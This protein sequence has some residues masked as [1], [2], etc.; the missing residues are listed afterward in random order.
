MAEKQYII[1][2]D[3]ERKFVILP[4]PTHE[5][6]RANLSLDSDDHIE[7]NQSV[8]Q[9]HKEILAQRARDLAT[10]KDRFLTLEESAVHICRKTG[11]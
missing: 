3:G 10:G 5:R 2:A 8:M 9:A 1:D 11:R 6:K 4:I 7:M